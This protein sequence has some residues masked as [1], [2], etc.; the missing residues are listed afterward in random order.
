MADALGVS[1]N[2]VSD[3]PGRYLV[4]CKQTKLPIYDAVP[5]R[6]WQRNKCARGLRRYKDATGASITTGMMKQKREGG[7]R[8]FCSSGF[9]LMQPTQSHQSFALNLG[10][11][12]CINHT[13]RA[14]AICE[15]TW[16]RQ[17]DLRLLESPVALMSQQQQLK[18]RESWK[19][20]FVLHSMPRFI[21]VRPQKA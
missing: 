16:L 21:P 7:R 18:A 14:C 5:L 17:L 2:V 15:I 13:F 11:A 20:T 8:G 4:S 3:Y 6:R 9:V 1:T 10:A 12:A 19:R